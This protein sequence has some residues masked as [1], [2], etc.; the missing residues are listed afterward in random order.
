[1]RTNKNDSRMNLL[2]SL[3]GAALLTG[4]L[5]LGAAVAAPPAQ[6]VPK[7]D[8]E[9][10]AGT[11]YELARLPNRPQDH[12]AGDVSATYTPNADGSVDMVNRCRK[13]N[14]DIDRSEGH[15]TLAPGDT[16]GAKLK[17]SF[18]P[19]WLQWFPLGRA[20]YWVVMLDSAYRYAVVSEPGKTS[21]RILSRTPEVDEGAYEALL[22]KLSL[23]GYPVDQLVRTSHATRPSPT[24]QQVQRLLWI[25]AS[26][27]KSQRVPL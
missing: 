13:A 23:A 25:G 27:V 11:W 10:Y 12:C 6:S 18:L 1:M 15:A 2:E 20:D 26:A 4:G 9:R 5:M 8:L 7:V 17:V 21:M 19:G 14:G 24:A 16:S 3:T 22:D